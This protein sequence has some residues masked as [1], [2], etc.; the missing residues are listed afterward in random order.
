[1]RIRYLRNALTSRI[2][3]LASIAIVATLATGPAMADPPSLIQ[4]L[5]RD[6]A[7]IVV[8]T[9]PAGTVTGYNVYQQVVTDPNSDLPAATK[10]NTDPIKETSF[11]VPGLTNG[12]CYHFTVTAIVDGKESAPAGPTLSNSDTEGAKVCV[13]PQKPTQL[14]GG[15]EFYGVTVG[16]DF[17]GSHSVDAK[18]VITMKA[19]GH[20]IY[21]QSD[22]FYF[23][24]M[25]MAGDVTVTVRCVSGPT[26]TAD[27][28]GWNLGGPMIRESLDSPSRFA[29][30]QIARDDPLQ[31][32]KRLTE[33]ETPQNNDNGRDDNTARPVWLRVVRKGDDFTAFF[34]EDGTD[35]TQVG[36]VA[37]ISGFAKE[38]FV[39]VALCGHQDGEYSTATFD[40][41]KITSP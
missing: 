37:N 4:Y 28:N 26:A 20:D 29:M 2:E 30:M 36:D 8:W 5:P 14:G 12:T 18:G 22:A 7:A 25:P 11:M 17:P 31:F 10:V 34:S 23:L 41:F 16:T 35:Y 24:A 40:D 33:G 19:S 3:L 9:A 13:S 1:M 27:E 6:G 32:K 21:G 39:G 38:P 15:G